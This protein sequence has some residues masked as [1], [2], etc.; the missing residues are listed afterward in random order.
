MSGK[1]VYIQVD[2]WGPRAPTDS[3]LQKIKLPETSGALD[4]VGVESSSVFCPSPGTDYSLRRGKWSLW[5]G[6]GSGV[7]LFVLRK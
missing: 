1:G 7:K 4:R 3:R 2:S 6:P 5:A